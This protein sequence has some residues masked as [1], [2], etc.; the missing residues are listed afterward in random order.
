MR[1]PPVPRSLADDVGAPRFGTYVGS[2][3]RVDLATLRGDFALSA[4]QRLLRH[5]RWL[6][7]FAATREVALLAA[8]VDVGYSANA[9]TLAVDLSTG[10]VLKDASALGLPGPMVHV[11]QEPD[12]GVAA[13]FSGPSLRIKAE[14]PVGRERLSLAVKA[15]APMLRGLDAE[16]ELL[17]A[18]AAPALTVVAPVDG[19]GVNVTMKRAGLLS[20]GTLKAGGKEFLLDGGVGGFDYTRGYLARRTA[21][22]WAFGCGRLDDGT[23]VGF[24]LVQGFNETRDD[25]NENAV[26]VGEK[27]HGLGRARFEWNKAE[28]L[29]PW[30]VRTVDGVLELSFKALAAHREERNL[31]LVKSHFVQPVGLFEGTLRLDGVTH[32]LTSLPGVTEDQ[33]V[34]W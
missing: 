21:W 28:P 32:R 20:F 33:D 23:P 34:L 19:S 13:R 11:S 6:Y 29:D 31:G 14:R 22:R 27:V 16:L 25:V 2:L 17:T 26:W 9:F 18:G 10:A 1:L 30:T 12:E 7:T 4:S 24:N 3:P 8:V 5:K 15:G